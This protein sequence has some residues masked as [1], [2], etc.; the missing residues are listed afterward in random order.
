[1]AELDIPLHKGFSNIVAAFGQK[2]ASVELGARPTECT[3]CLFVIVVLISKLSNGCIRLLNGSQIGAL[4]VLDGGC[5]AR[6]NI[7]HFTNNRGDI[8]YVQIDADIETGVPIDDFV[9]IVSIEDRA[10]Q[11]GLND[12][13][14]PDAFFHLCIAGLIATLTGVILWIASD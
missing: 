4:D 8:R 6:L 13:F 11:D 2:D 14:S 5:A 10:Q 3:A 1:M 7:G 9:W 12:T